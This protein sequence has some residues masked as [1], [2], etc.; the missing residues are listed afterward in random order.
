MIDATDLRKGVAFEI[1]GQL[2]TVIEYQHIKV[3]RGSAQVKLRLRDI[4]GGHTL[5]RTFQSGDKFPRVRLEQREAQ[6]L[7]QDSGIYYFMDSESFEQT[8]LTLEKLEDALRYIKE[9][10]TLLITKYGDETIG[11]EVPLMV[12]L[13]VTETGPVFKGDTAQGGTKPAKM[14]TGINIQVPFFINTGDVVRVDTRTGSYV[15]RTS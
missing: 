11:V 1:D 4:R 8:P 15:E 12:D 13:E 2:Y 7:Y 3:A 6:Y 10:M 5:E 9:G 14:E